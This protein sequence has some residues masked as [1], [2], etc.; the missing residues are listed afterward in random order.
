MK[1]KLSINDL[2][3]LDTELAIK[4]SDDTESYIPLKILRDNCPCANCS[5]EKDVLGNVYKGK[6]KQLNENSYIVLNLSK[7]GHYALRIFWG[8][9]HSEGLFSFE[10]LKSFENDATK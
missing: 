6:S 10:L 9:G 4:W 2:L 3:F 1:E 7:V 5:G 8:D